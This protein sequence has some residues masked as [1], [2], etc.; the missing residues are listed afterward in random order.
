MREYF[1]YTLE[2]SSGIPEVT[3]LGT[4]ED[5]VSIRTRAAAFTEL[6]LSGWT[7]ALLPV[8]DRI[9]ESARGD[10]DPAFWQSFYKHK[11]QSGGPYVTGWINVLFPYIDAR[12]SHASQGR[13]APN[14]HAIQWAEGLR[15]EFAGGPPI[16]SFSRGLR[17][18]PFEWRYYSTTI[19]MAFAGGF[20]GVSQDAAT[21]AVR[22][23]IGW[24]IGE[25]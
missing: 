17:S 3:L 11:N 9:V 24:A 7:A 6:D 10:A 16:G 19:P 21:G 5:W 13:H 20:V 1:D 12:V 18:V 14:L 2:T 23:A 4:V 22:P 8:L 25:R 15:A